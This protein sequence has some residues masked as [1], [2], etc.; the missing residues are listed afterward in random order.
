MINQEAYKDL[1]ELC[2]Q[3]KVE[4]IAVSKTQTIEAIQSLYELG[5][6]HF[7][8]N[9][10]EELVVKKAS[11]PEDIIWH[12]IGHLQ[13][14]KARKVVALADWIH[15]GDS[16]SLLDEIEKRAMQQDKQMNVLLQFHIASESSKQGFDINSEE[17]VFADYQSKWPSLKICGVM[18]MATYT[19]DSEVVKSEFRRLK[20]RFELLQKRSFSGIEDFQE[21]SMGMSGDFEIAIDEGSTMIRV[22]SLIFGNR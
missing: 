4:L 18:G 15:S 10:L 2:G 22:G 3:K 17:E 12:F 20:E 13:R 11:L 6:R 5:Q 8:E 1:V 7:G 14:K 21:I 16:L 19:Q 9:R